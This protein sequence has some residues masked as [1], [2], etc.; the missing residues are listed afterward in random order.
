M[1]RMRV[2]QISVVLR[3][4][5]APNYPWSTRHSITYDIPGTA[6]LQYTT[7]VLVY[8]MMAV[9]RQVPCHG[10]AR[11]LKAAYNI[12]STTFIP[13]ILLYLLHQEVNFTLYTEKG[14]L[15]ILGVV[16]IGSVV[17]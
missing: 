9:G 11:L 8:I 5:G 16:F 7:V 15:L 3:R 1:P 2:G 17:S 4:E 10:A 6:T 12:F 13:L 14:I